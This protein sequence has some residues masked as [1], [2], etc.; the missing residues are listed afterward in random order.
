VRFFLLGPLEVHASG[1]EQVILSAAK[2]RTVLAVLL[3]HANSRVSVDRLTATLWPDRPPRSAPGNVRT[4]VSALRRVLHL[5]SQDHLPRLSF[6][7]GGYRLDL[8]PSELDLLVFEDLERRGRQALGN[9]DFA[10]AARLLRDALRLWRGQPA[11]D[12]ALGSDAAA[13]LAGL[14]ERRLTAEEAWID[15]RLAQGHDAELIVRL[16]AL[17]T[18]HPLREQLWHRLMMALYEAGRQAEALATFQELRR[19]V[20]EELGIEP[21]PQIQRLQRQI[22]AGER[23]D[24]GSHPVATAP[25]ATALAAT[26]P[27]ATAPAA[28]VPPRQ[29]TP[30]IPDFTGRSAEIGRLR[31]VITVRRADERAPAAIV[32]ISG[33]AG[34]GKTALAVHWAHQVI[35]RFGDGQLY[36]NLR[37][38]GP[39]RPMDPLEALAQFLRALGMPA[40]Q[41]PGGLDE[42]AASYRSLLVGRRMLILLDNAVTAQ[43]VRPLLPGTPGCLVLVTS[44]SRLPGLAARDG[45]AQLTLDPLTEPDAVALLGKIMGSRRVLDQPQAA[46]EIAARCSYLP[47]SLRIAA[48]YAANRAYLPLAELAAQLAGVRDR[49]DVLAA[50]EDEATNM[51]TVFSWSYLAL[52]ADAARM[53]RLVGLHAGPDISVLAAASLA[54]TDER[55]ARRLLDVLA[56]VHM[57]EEG[58]PGRY[59]FHDLLGA[60]AADQARAQESA[61]DRA[62]ARLRILTWQ[63]HAADAATALM[64][65]AQRR[66][67]LD[68]APPDCALP[69]FDGYAGAL[70]WYDDERAS[71][72]AAV[73][74]AA[75]TGHDD[76]AW[77]LAATIRYYFTLRKPQTDWISICRTGLASARRCGDRRGEAWMLNDLGGGYFDLRRLDDALTS[78]SKALDIRR[79]LGDRPGEA[80][81]LNNLGII[82]LELRQFR[83]AARSARQA[84]ALC[85]VAGDRRD[86]AAAL[87]GLGEIHRK[88]G[89]PAQSLPCFERS[90]ALF[91]DINERRGECIAL[92]SIGEGYHD[93]RRSGEG[94]GYLRQALAIHRQVSDRPGEAE[95]LRTL[96]DLLI[97]V[98]QPEAA[99]RCWHQALVILDDLRDPRAAE[100]RDRLAR[101]R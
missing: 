65:P 18:G 48:D 89:R 71:L 96:G 4:Y 86:E 27:G 101:A 59:R 95:A 2:Q 73:D 69:V 92:Q 39:N 75:R 7:R 41:V 36:V 99:R 88:L 35:G 17:V 23:L 6:E 33:T 37:G 66:V 25:A 78:V 20:V 80:L 26:A 100:I 77:K 24:F 29:L 68:A 32:A 63:L 90:L 11:E 9:G 87:H 54:A 30:D 70:A 60:Y 85:R 67:Q 38:Y 74:L 21:G 34:A 79:E 50:G 64:S 12:V 49:L 28:A 40:G 13:A 72:V 98:S 55:G 15:A 91:R 43:Q 93:L 76:I 42:A 58:A 94:V 16:R 51:R 19:R 53:F 47:L 62:A 3:L 5:D 1:G 46:A 45:A 82:Y 57:A 81:C 31:A 97:A 44:R 56:G 61:R 52:P 83:C 84:L 10:E 8:A 22:L 14:E